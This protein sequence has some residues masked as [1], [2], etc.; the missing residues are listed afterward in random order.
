MMSRIASVVDPSKIDYI[1][2]NH[3]EMDHTGALPEVIDEVKPEKVFASKMGVDALN[4]HFHFDG[5]VTPIQDGQTLDLG[6]KTVTF[7]ETRMLH[8]PDSMFSFLHEDGILFSQDGF[9]MHLASDE[10]FDDELDEC[11]LKSEASKYFANILTPYAGLITKLIEKMGKLDL[12]IKMVAPDHGPVWRKNISKVVGW[13]SEWAEQKPTKKAV[14]F[15]DTMWQSTAS[16]AAS[17]ADGVTSSGAEAKVMPLHGTHR[18]DVATELLDAGAIVVGSPTINN[19]MFPTV[20]DV[21]TYIKGLKF[22]NLIGAAFGSHGWSGEAVKLVQAEL[23]EMKVDIVAEGMTGKYV[24][25]EEDLEKCFSMG[26]ILGG[27]LI[28]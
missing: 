3:A 28:K 23:S 13:Y 24:P 1:I 14:I 17:I 18:S 8:W 15:Y 26:K 12:P 11:L 2:S 19:Q 4:A 20:A 6:G 10:R 22:K 25:R 27:K 21:L 9:G 16:M 5:D 7:Y